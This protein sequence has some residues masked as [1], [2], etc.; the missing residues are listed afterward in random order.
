[1][2]EC[3]A[4]SEVDTCPV[5]ISIDELFVGGESEDLVADVYTALGTLDA[6]CPEAVATVGAEDLRRL[7]A[8]GARW[9]ELG[10]DAPAEQIALLAAVRRVR[11][12]LERG[13][14]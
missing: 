4:R 7:A 6:A 12:L 5:F 14:P 3:H 2:A 10:V 13:Q 11:H 1:V 9:A 8:A